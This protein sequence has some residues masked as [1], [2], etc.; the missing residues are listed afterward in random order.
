MSFSIIISNNKNRFK[1][2][3]NLIII[4]FFILYLLIGFFLINHYQYVAS[5]DGM[6]YINIAKLYIDGNLQNA[7]NGYWG[8]LFSWL[9]IPFIKVFG[10]SPLNA[11]YAA[12][13]LSIIIGAFT[14]LGA[15]LLSYRFDMDNWI[16][17]VCFAI[18]IPL[19]LSISL[20]P[21]QPDLLLACFLTYYLY[22]IFDPKYKETFKWSIM[23]SY[24]WNCIFNK[25]LCFTI[26]FASFHYIQ[27][28]E[29]VPRFFQRK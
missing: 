16:K 28:F 29:L 13:F 12:R 20:G 26:L 4:L 21:V 18:I 14:L 15:L 6:S 7:I 22:L 19:V 27:L 3:F 25:S 8:P 2:R 23:W 5:A 11:V 17:G 1:N 10:T 9:M 24:S